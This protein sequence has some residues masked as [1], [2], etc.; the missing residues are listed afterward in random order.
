MGWVI[1]SSIRH[2]TFIQ[3]CNYILLP[4]VV[5]LTLHLDQHKIHIIDVFLVLFGKAREPYRNSPQSY[6][7]VYT[8]SIRSSPCIDQV[9][10]IYLI[11]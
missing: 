9:I 4:A 6:A 1:K 5:H 2:S 8:S 3:R 7:I 10:A 11:R